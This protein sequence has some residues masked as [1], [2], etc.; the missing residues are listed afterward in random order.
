MRKV[1]SP[2]GETFRCPSGE[3]GAVPT[4]N[5]CC[6]RMKSHSR[7]SRRSYSLPI[8]TSRQNGISNQIDSAFK[9]PGKL[10][11][12]RPIMVRLASGA[13]PSWEDVLDRVSKFILRAGCSE[14][15]IEVKG[16]ADGESTESASRIRS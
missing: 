14:T 2:L 15:F 6:R 7:S 9:G 10:R 8:M 16:T 5:T 12:V 4:K 3:L 1:S 11:N 13:N